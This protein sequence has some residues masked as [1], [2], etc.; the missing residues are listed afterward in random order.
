MPKAVSLV[1]TSMW[2]LATADRWQRGNDFQ[3]VLGPR[4]ERLLIARSGKK[5]PLRRHAS[6]LF[7]SARE[8]V[9]V[10]LRKHYA[11]SVTKRRIE[12]TP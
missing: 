8:H 3:A 6:F 9:A 12:D 10:I 11:R 1:S 7:G 2:L 5:P 4:A